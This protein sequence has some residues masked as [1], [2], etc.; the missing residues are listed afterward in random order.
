[1]KIKSITN[2]STYILFLYLFSVLFSVKAQDLKLSYPKYAENADANLDSLVAELQNM[3]VAFVGNNSSRNENGLV[4]ILLKN[5]GVNVVKIFSPE[6]GFLV[7]AD[8]GK[9]INEETTIEGIKIVSLYGKKLMP[10][11]TDME[12]INT[13]VFDIQ[14]V[15]VRFYTY[16]STLTYIMKSCAINNIELI[17]LDRY[18]FHAHYTDGPLLDMN[19]KSYVG[20]HPVPVVYGMTI[21]EYALMVNGENWLTLGDS[22]YNNKKLQCKLKVYKCKNYYRYARP[23][24]AIKNAPSPN[25]ATREAIILYPS[26]CFMEGTTMSV[27]RGTTSPFEQ[28]GSP[29]YKIRNY[30]F[31]PIAN[32]SNTEPMYKGKKC[33]GKK[34]TKQE[35]ELLE[36]KLSLQFLM[37]A[38]K[39]SKNNAKFFNTFFNK[40]AGNDVLMAQIKSGKTE[41]EIKESWQ[42]DLKNFELI[43]QKYL[44]Y[45]AN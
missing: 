20:M 34:I 7:N 19:Y 16:I 24:G 40:L 36:N 6:H 11:N 18:N 32:I 42:N 26:L 10:S 41:V 31:R 9:K 33:W 12:G 28:Y 45:K 22:A 13:V 2:Y 37:D 29:L 27:G 1:M 43:R 35:M 14:D 15:G 23:K 39:N 8:A 25:L 44:L 17:V 3:N 21:G 30:S 5:M 38:F 4:P